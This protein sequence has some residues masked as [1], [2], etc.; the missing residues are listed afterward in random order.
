MLLK[1]PL[2][3][4]KLV[5]F[6]FPLSPL[7][8][9][10]MLNPLS[11]RNDPLPSRKKERRKLNR[12]SQDCLEDMQTFWGLEYKKKFDAFKRSPVVPG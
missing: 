3:P 5:S 11:P 8:E 10:R 12:I 1:I 6:P 7:K 9:I 4:L 2:D